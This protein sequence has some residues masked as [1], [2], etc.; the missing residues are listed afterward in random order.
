MAL[1]RH[2]L[3]GEAVARKVHLRFAVVEKPT[4]MEAGTLV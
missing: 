2:N 1:K 3:G 4:I